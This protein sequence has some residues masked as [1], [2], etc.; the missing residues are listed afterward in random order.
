MRLIDADLFMQRIESY[1]TSDKMDKALYN[2]ALHEIASM[3][4]VD[5]LDKI[6]TRIEREADYYDA[7]V[8]ADIAEGLYMA[9]ELIEQYTKEPEK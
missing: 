5:V 7:E 8:N 6:K 1:N 9:L 4:T 3:P 2:F